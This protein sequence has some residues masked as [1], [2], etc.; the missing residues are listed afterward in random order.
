MLYRL[1]PPPMRG[2]QAAAA[3]S[4]ALL[5]E[6][7]I[8]VHWRTIESL[9][10]AAPKLAT[11]RKRQG[12]WE[13]SILQD[14]EDFVRVPDDK[15]LFIDPENAVQAVL[16]LHD[17][18]AGLVGDAR[19]CDPYLDDSTIEHLA[20]APKTVPIRL[21]TSNVKDSGKLRQLLKATKTEGRTIDVRVT[22]TKSLHDRYLID[23]NRMII[24]GTSL[25]GFAKKQSFLVLVG[26]DFRAELANVFDRYW[27]MA[28]AWP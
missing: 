24:M 28:Q 1:A 3:I 26:P 12:S 18:L 23:D 16:T 2:W 25:N 22:P 19:L 15:V 27:S 13:F 11:R 8:R 5:A 17:L 21:L 4:Q 10:R 7:G 20:S 6:F 14:G 9:L